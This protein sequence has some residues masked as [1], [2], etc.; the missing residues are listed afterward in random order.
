MFSVLSFARVSCAGSILTVP[1]DRGQSPLAELK[2]RLESARRLSPRM[3]NSTAPV[4]E[5]GPFRLDTGVH[6]LFRDGV[7]V[8]L[9]PKAFE[10]LL[11]LVEGTGK[12]I[13]K[14][15]LMRRLWP[16]TIVEEG[17]LAVTVFALRKALADTSDPPLIETVPRRGYRFN[18]IVKEIAATTREAESVQSVAIL[19]FKPLVPQEENVLLG[20]GMADAV[21]TRLSQTEEIIVRPTGAVAPYAAPGQDPIEAGRSLRVDA[22]L[23]GHLQREAGQIRVTVQLLRTADGKALWA[24]RFHVAL[25]NLFEVQD[26]IAEAVGAALIERLSEPSRLRWRKR[27][28]NS[29]QAYRSYLWGQHYNNQRTLDSCLRAIQ[30][31]E[32][33]AATDPHYALAYAGIGDALSWTSHFYLPPAEVM[34]KARTAARTALGLDERLGEAHCVMAEVKKWFDWDFEGAARHYRRAIELNPGHAYA[35]LYY[36]IFRVQMGQSGWESEVA[37]M[38]RIDPV[39]N[40]ALC[41]GGVPY[42]YTRRHAEAIDFQSRCLEAVPGFWVAEIMLSWSYEQQGRLL[43]AASTAEQAIEHSGRSHVC[44]AT[45]GYCLAK[46]GERARAEEVLTS[47]VSSP[48]GANYSSP[49]YRALIHAALGNKDEAFSCL[50]RAVAERAGWLAYARVDPKLDVLRDDPRFDALLR[51]VGLI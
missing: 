36:A 6:N 2:F 24:D 18:G 12:L 33:A 49:Y 26:S 23:D 1:G 29:P 46:L 9:T 7:P 45:L 32:E 22:V 50:Q 21:I 28:T 30:C 42:Y 41:G 38:L 10:L 17:N 34:P 47:L 13:A 11:A 40:I 16:E 19:P 44:L 35:H 27:Y 31:F 8:P 20:F 14:E 15:A 4:Y 3:E 39:S 37:A 51:Q 43:E 5:F 25:Q 48:D